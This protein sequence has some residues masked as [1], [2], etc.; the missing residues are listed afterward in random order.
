MTT[1]IQTQNKKPLTIRD[2]LESPAFAAQVAKTL[3]KHLTSERFI[4]VA[5]TAMMRTPK[6]AQCEQVSFFN[7]LL[8]LSQ[9]GI[10]PDGRRA[11]LIPFENRKRGVTEVQLI[12][13]FK[14]LVELAIRS[15]SVANIHADV[16]CVSDDFEYNCGEIAKHRINFK[17]PRGEMY[18]AY[19]T[20]TFKDGTKKCEVMSKVEIDGIRSRSRAGQ[21]G[22]WVTDYNE[23]AKKTVFR[24]LSKWLPLSPE[25]RDGIE[26]D[27]DQYS[28]APK[29]SAPVFSNPAAAPLFADAVDQDVE[30][31]PPPEADEVPMGENP[32]SPMRHE[33]VEFLTGQSVS[34]DDFRSFVSTKNIAKDSDTWA[35]WSEVPT[36]VFDVL[37][38]QPKTMSELIRKFGK[39]A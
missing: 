5:C 9:L 30:S 4:R 18:A 17:E 25:I 12:V 38:A 37:K 16:V 14:G 21:S 32:N 34:F 39:V 6:L 7:A 8:T 29:M 19:A 10:E 33:A 3:P 2:Q 22:P 31:S 27:D 13:D 24:R 11:H 23:M 35:D 1:S 26:A 36:A 15:G 28:N 20:C